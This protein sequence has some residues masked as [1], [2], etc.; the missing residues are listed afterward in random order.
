MVHRGEHPSDVRAS[1]LK[2]AHLTT[3]HLNEYRS[4]WTAQKRSDV[5]VNLE[6]AILRIALNLGRKFTPPKVTQLPWF[7]MKKEDNARQGFLGDDQY[8]KLRDA[9][10][11]YL[12][13]LFATAYFT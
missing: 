6:L 8:A 10:P 5:T 1:Q 7:P 12:K 13:P 9:L 2:A 4:K 11:D 3:E